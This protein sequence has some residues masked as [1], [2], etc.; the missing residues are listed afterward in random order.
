MSVRARSPPLRKPPSLAS[1]LSDMVL[2]FLRT[3]IRHEINTPL[4]EMVTRR[5]LKELKSEQLR[6][7]Y[8]FNRDREIG[9]RRYNLR[10]LGEPV[11]YSAIL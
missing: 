3:I 8:A 7:D 4:M 1:A 5:A 9:R 11:P 6:V 2:S 10:S